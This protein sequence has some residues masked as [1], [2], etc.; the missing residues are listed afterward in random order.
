MRISVFYAWQSDSPQLTNLELIDQALRQAVARVAAD[1]ALIMTPEVDRDTANVPGAPPMA[2]TILE[3]IDACSVFVADVTLTYERRAGDPRL[4]PN[5]N[6]L[7]ELGYAL[8][9]L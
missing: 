3:K 1:G 6:V 5:P 4:S 9:R 8:K 2:A 7:L